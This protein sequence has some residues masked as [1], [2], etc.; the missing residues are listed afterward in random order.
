MADES[1]VKEA[2]SLGLASDRIREAAKWLIVSF[3][4]VGVTLFGGLQLA[5]I[6]QLSA[7]QPS[8]LIPAALGF[9]LGLVGLALAIYAA[10]SVVTESYASLWWLTGQANEQLRLALERDPTLLGG[11]PTIASLMEE[12]EQAQKRRKEAYGA[13]YAE[14]P[15]GES[16]SDRKSRME[17]VDTEFYHASYTLQSLAQ[18]EQRVLQVASFDRVGKAYE[19]SRTK[20]FWGAGIAA[21]GIGLFAWGVN[22]PASPKSVKAEQVLPPSPSNVTAVINESG[23]DSQ[24]VSGKSLRQALGKDCDLSKVGAIALSASGDTYDLVS[25]KTDKCNS[26]YFTVNPSQG[27]VVPRKAEQ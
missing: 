27:K 7:D 25:L 14:A 9:L 18:V 2:P 24:L 19:E 16:D 6:G 4:A 12:I 8:R 1:K 5:N 13:R 3:A 26:V 20:M 17:R 23:A 11:Y 22:Q 15:E 21:L 10:S